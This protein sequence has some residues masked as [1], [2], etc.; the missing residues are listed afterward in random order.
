MT[1]VFSNLD[2]WTHQALQGVGSLMDFV[3][4]PDTPPEPTQTAAPTPAHEQSE[5]FAALEH[6]RD[7]QEKGIITAEEFEAQKAKLLSRL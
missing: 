2:T 6:L 5:I 4:K 7:L 3:P 1:E